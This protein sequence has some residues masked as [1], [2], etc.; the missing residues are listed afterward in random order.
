ML[1]ELQLRCQGHYGYATGWTGYPYCDSACSK[2]NTC[3]EN[4]KQRQGLDLLPANMINQNLQEGAGDKMG[5]SSRHQME[6]NK[7]LKPGDPPSD[8]R[9]D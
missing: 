8:E 2:R 9:T 7:D 5:G 4:V 6:F 3:L 1:L